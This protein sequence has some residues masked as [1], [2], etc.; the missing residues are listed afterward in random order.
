MNSNRQS[1]KISFFVKI[2]P[3]EKWD[4]ILS[5]R[6]YSHTSPV[7]KLNQSV[8]HHQI[9]VS[10]RRE[11]MHAIKSLPMNKYVASLNPGAVDEII[12]SWKIL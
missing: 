1:K 11:K 2:N 12:A 8:K 4:G 7:G 10:S 5:K 6:I 9:Y 3:E